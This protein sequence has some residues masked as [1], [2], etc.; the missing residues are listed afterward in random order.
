MS[1]VQLLTCQIRIT[2]AANN[3][4]DKNTKITMERTH[5][6]MQNDK[7]SNNDDC[8]VLYLR[9][10]TEDIPYFYDEKWRRFVEKVSRLSCSSRCFV[11]FLG[12]PF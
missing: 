5:K 9:T 7:I 1:L 2:T 11:L 6:R 12:Q 10:I 8:T 3:V 4:I